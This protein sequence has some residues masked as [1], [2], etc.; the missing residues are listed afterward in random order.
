MDLWLTNM[1]YAQMERL[2]QGLKLKEWKRDQHGLGLRLPTSEIYLRT[3]ER[4]ASGYTYRRQDLRGTK[5]ATAWEIDST[6]TPRED[7]SQDSVKK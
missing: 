3:L 6:R 7:Q 2:L 5:K 4:N 1:D